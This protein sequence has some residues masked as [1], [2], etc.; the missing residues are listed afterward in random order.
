MSG[1]FIIS[2]VSD[3]DVWSEV[4]MIKS[5]CVC[6]FYPDWHSNLNCSHIS[7]QHQSSTSK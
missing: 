5:V 1:H 7:L 3:D 6:V 2:T 4:T